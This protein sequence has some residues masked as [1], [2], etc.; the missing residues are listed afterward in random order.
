[1]TGSIQEKNG[2]WYTVIAYKDSNGRWK[3]KWQSTKLSVVGNKKRAEAILK[4]RLREYEQIN[5]EYIGDQQLFSDFLKSWLGVVKVKIQKTT[6]DGYVH[7]INSHIS[8]YFEKQKLYV[9]EIMP[10]HIQKYYYVKLEE[11]LSPNTVLK[12]H[13]VIRTALQFAV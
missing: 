7:M 10:Y 11:G 6:Y 12:H 9:R 2:F 8:P 13:S 4:E 3:Y 1:M 5:E